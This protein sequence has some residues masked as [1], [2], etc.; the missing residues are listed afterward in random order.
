MPAHARLAQV[1]PRRPDEVADDLR[2]LFDALPIVGKIARHR[3]RAHDHAVGI[4][5]HIDVIAGGGI[6]ESDDI[7]REGNI[8]DDLFRRLP[9]AHPEHEPAQFGSPKV[10]E[11]RSCALFAVGLAFGQRLAAVLPFVAVDAHAFLDINVQKHVDAA[12]HGAGRIERMQKIAHLAA[13]FYTLFGSRLRHLVPDGIHHHA[14]MIEVLFHHCAEVILVSLKEIAR[15]VVI[16]FGD[17]PAV[18][19]LVH[20]VHA[21][22]IARIEERPRGG[23]VRNAQ[24]VKPLLF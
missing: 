18:E 6:I 17:I 23:V 3:L 2:I 8:R 5:L 22:L 15:I 20:D 24:G 10:E 11:S 4:F 21:K 9:L 19:A 14:R 1:V 16:V 12:R 13:E 7:E